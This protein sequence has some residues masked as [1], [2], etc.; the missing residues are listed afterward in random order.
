MYYKDY[1]AHVISCRQVHDVLNE[2]ICFLHYMAIG[3][4]IYSLKCCML[5]CQQTHKH[6]KIIIQSQ[7]TTVN[8]HLFA[9]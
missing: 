8:H 6:I 3:K 1:F 4:C 9:E 5:L 7:L 2:F